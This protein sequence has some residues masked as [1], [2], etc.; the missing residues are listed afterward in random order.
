MDYFPLCILQKGFLS[1]QLSESLQFQNAFRLLLH[2]ND[3]A[4][5]WLRSFSFHVSGHELTVMS[6]RGSKES[7]F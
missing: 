6:A 1:E 3:I 4:V 7:E 2:T 5:F